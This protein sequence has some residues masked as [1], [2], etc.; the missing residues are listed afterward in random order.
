MATEL[1]KRH[2][3]LKKRLEKTVKDKSEVVAQLKS[4]FAL[5]TEQRKALQVSIAKSKRLEEDNQR[6]ET[7]KTAQD[8]QVRALTRKIEQ[9]DQE[10]ELLAARHRRERESIETEME[11]K[12]QLVKKLEGDVKE[13]T[14]GKSLMKKQIDEY[15]SKVKK[16]I[17]EFEETSKKHIREL[18]EVHE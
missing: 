1:K 8:D 11:E 10:R 14:S 4:L 9:M 15:E 13:A 7:A 12:R 5:Y 17:Y 3:M 18:N 16:L 2:D 6:L